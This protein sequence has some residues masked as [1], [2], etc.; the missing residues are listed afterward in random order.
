MDT[1]QLHEVITQRGIKPE[2]LDQVAARVRSHFEGSNP[3]PQDV[4]DYILALPLWERLGMTEAGF[5]SYPATWR[6]DQ[7]RAHQAPPGP[8]RPVTREL[9]KEEV[10]ALDAEGLPWAERREKARQLQQSPLP[11][12]R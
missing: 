9:T 12:P 11:E 2:A 10:A 7:A 5:L 3:T 8:R 1:K 6:L 4:A